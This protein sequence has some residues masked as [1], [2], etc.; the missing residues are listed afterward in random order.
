[1][2]T[3]V[4]DGA[5]K[6][7]TQKSETKRKKKNSKVESSPPR[8]EGGGRGGVSSRAAIAD[9]RQSTAKVQKNILKAISFSALDAIL[10]LGSSL[11]QPLPAGRGIHFSVGCPPQEARTIKVGSGISPEAVFWTSGLCARRIT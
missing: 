2:G 4:E 5:A 9:F 11:P 6:R 1:M 10:L 3:I 8:G 7:E